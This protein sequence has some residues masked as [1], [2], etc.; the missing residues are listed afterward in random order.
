[1]KMK[2][3]I[4]TAVI[5]G[6]IGFILLSPAPEQG[7]DGPVGPN[8]GEPA[9]DFELA[10]LDGKTWNLSALR[11][12]V[13]IVNFWATWCPPC[14]A[15]MPSLSRLYEELKARGDFEVL[16]ILYND[17]P[18]TASQYVRKN[19]FNFP[20]LK[21]DNRVTGDYGVTGVPETYI[22]DKQGIL[23]RKFKGPVEFDAPSM[24]DFIKQLLA[25]PG[26]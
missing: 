22:V 13:V 14:K 15:E 19:G 16:G 1:M 21:L 8:V 12:S 26:Q 4:V 2:W 10:G 20:I 6:F 18:E 17:L 25:E 7:V 9:P 5:L 24:H 23:R 11:G 3:L